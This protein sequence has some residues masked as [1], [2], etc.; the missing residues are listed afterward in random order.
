MVVNHQLWEFFHKIFG[1]GPEI[2]IFSE[3]IEE[4]P[5]KIIYKR[6]MFKYVKI[7]CIVLP[8]KKNIIISENEYE[9]KN[10]TLKDIQRFY[11]F[12]NKYKKVDDL[13][14]YIKQIMKGYN[15]KIIDMNNYKCWIDLNYDDFKILDKRI[16]RKISDIY[17]M[18]NNNNLS[19]LNLEELEKEDEKENENEDMSSKK[20][21]WI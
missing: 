13:L 21:I 19:P 2:K 14:I 5:G 8:P 9:Y 17:K 11:T 12:F 3:K 16:S 7:N 6:D 15:I 1:G 20:K 10:E 4:E 18:N